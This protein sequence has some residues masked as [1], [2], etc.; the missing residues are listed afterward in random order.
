MVSN[1]NR[2]DGSKITLE[3]RDEAMRRRKVFGDW[4]HE[5]L[6]GDTHT[7]IMVAP[8]GSPE[9]KYRDEVPASVA[10]HLWFRAHY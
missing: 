3:E 5:Q 2:D 1:R 4:T 8:Y 10:I 9:P 7:T 6:I